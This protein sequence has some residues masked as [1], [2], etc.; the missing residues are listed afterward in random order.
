[1]FWLIGWRGGAPDD[2]S[3]SRPILARHGFHCETLRHEI[4]LGL[5]RPMRARQRLC[6]GLVV[7][8]LGGRGTLTLLALLEPIA[9]AVHLQDVDVVREPVEQGA[10]EPLGGEYLGLCQRRRKN[11]PG[12]RSKTRSADDDALPGLPWVRCRVFLE[13]SILGSGRGSDLA[14]FQVTALRRGG[15]CVPSGIGY[16]G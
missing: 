3:Q 8:R 1:M 16:N 2:D 13:V 11:R 10:S 6:L 7:R 4:L 9:V 5:G 14:C 15:M 12:W